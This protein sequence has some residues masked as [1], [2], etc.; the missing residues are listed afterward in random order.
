MGTGE[1]DTSDTTT[2]AAVEARLAF[3]R[4]ELPPLPTFATEHSAPEVVSDEDLEP[5][6]DEPAGTWQPPFPPALDPE[7]QY[8]ALVDR[9]SAYAEPVAA[10]SPVITPAPIADPAPVPVQD[11]P[12]RSMRVPAV[13]TTTAIPELPELAPAP[14][15]APRP[16][17]IVAIAGMTALAVFLVWASRMAFS[18][19]LLA[20]AGLLFAQLA[21]AA[22]ASGTSS[23]LPLLAGIPALGLA[24]SAAKGALGGFSEMAMVAGLFVIAAGVVSLLVLG[25]VQ[26]VMHRRAAR[27]GAAETMLRDGW[28]VRFGALLAIIAAGV[29]VKDSFVATPDAILTFAMVGL[30]LA[31]LAPVARGGDSAAS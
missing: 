11:P 2:D 26:L 5:H 30:V 1:P 24:V 7:A 3:P 12:R 31:T 28:K 13:G 27:A 16:M 18:P 15:L 17:T 4:L 29:Y 20:Y 6:L 21:A 23:R 22:T 8:R 10:A 19:A 9:V 25:I 14:A